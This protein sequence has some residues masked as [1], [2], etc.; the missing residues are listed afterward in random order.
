M[1]EKC[2]ICQKH[3]GAIAVPG[4]PIYEDELV[5][6]GHRLPY[7]PDKPIENFYLGYFFV[8][9]K[10]HITSL[11]DLSEAEAKQIGWLTTR[12]GQALRTSENADHIYLFVLGRPGRHLHYH[13]VSRYPNAPREY[14]GIHVDEWPDAPRG[15]KQDIETLCTRIRNNM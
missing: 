3:S 13:V 6:I 9:P 1:S 12:V 15:N 7:P 14:W 2:F 10:R 8:E 5:F 4:G 11:A